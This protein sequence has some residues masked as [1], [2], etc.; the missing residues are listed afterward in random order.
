MP[1][2]MPQPA[3]LTIRET[4]AFL[5][6]HP[7]TLYLWRLKGTGPRWH[8]LESGTVLYR[9]ADLEAWLRSRANG[10]RAGR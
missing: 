1:K 2:A 7:R 6:R 3:L 5:R 4:A 9:R 10:G 8:K